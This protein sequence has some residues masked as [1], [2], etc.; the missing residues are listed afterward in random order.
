MAVLSGFAFACRSRC[1]SWMALSA[2]ERKGLRLGSQASLLARACTLRRKATV[3]TGHT[4]LISLTTVKRHHTLLLPLC[5]CSVRWEVLQGSRLRLSTLVFLPLEM[6]FLIFQ[7]CNLSFHFPLKHQPS[8][9]LFVHKVFLPCAISPAILNKN[10][11]N[12]I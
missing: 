3:K 7:L 9:C 1:F 6:I 4:S 5:H 10:F 2:V 11:S 12:W 8:H